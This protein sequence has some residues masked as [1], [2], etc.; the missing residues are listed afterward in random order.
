MN[1]INTRKTYITD[2]LRFG[3]ILDSLLSYYLKVKVV[4][5]KLKTLP[6]MAKHILPSLF[7]DLIVLKSHDL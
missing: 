4:K 2:K 3:S 7:I 5:V 6:T 1:K